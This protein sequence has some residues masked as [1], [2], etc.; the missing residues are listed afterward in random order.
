MSEARPRRLR[1]TLGGMLILVA[2]IAVGIAYL[3]PA[4][5]RVVDV[6]VGT[7]P[8]VKVGDVAAV[9]Y[10]GTLADGTVFDAS[11]GRGQP[12]EFGVGTGMAIRGWD[13]GLVG[14]R[15]GGVR[16]L[17]IP[18]AEGYGETGSGSVI[19]PN[20]TLE[21]EIE[22]IGIKPGVAGGTQATD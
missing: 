10:V 6:K 17:T 13:V 20:A 2:L 22:L 21:F 11:K 4:V 7:G 15:A 12:F 14:M 3:K 8:P 5:T 18:P 1:L 9:H 16:R 19:P